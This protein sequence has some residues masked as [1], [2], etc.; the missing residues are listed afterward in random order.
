MKFVKYSN[1]FELKLI[2][3]QIAFDA[4]TFSIFVAV[5]A[6]CWAVFDNK[7]IYQRF[8]TRRDLMLQQHNLL[9]NFAIE[10]MRKVKIYAQYLFTVYQNRTWQNFNV[11]IINA[12]KYQERIKENIKFMKWK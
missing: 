8:K 10:F 9:K 6:W 1:V 12:K 2:K 7:I 4:V 5:F 3:D 11:L